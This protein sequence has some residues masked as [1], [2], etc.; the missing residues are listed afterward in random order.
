MALCGKDCGAISLTGYSGH[1][2]FLRPVT[3]LCS[4]GRVSFA[5][6]KANA[7]RGSSLKDRTHVSDKRASSFNLLFW[8][9]GTHF[10]SSLAA[11]FR[12]GVKG[13]F[14][15]M[16]LDLAGHFQS[17]R[18]WFSKDFITLLEYFTS[19]IRFVPVFLMHLFQRSGSFLG[20]PESSPFLGDG[21][22]SD[23]PVLSPR[24]WEKNRCFRELLMD[25]KRWKSEGARP[26]LSSAVQELDDS[27]AEG[28]WWQE[29]P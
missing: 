18:T 4:F 2:L 10:G 21:D 27:M 24:R 3:W 29:L 6:G 15:K 28:C 17:F 1:Y 11:S 14:V 16:V 20:A 5:A 12:S 8:K 7:T 9:A 22:A 26:L 23:A 25:S 19:T 13:T